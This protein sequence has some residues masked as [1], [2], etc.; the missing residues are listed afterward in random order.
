MPSQRRSCARRWPQQRLSCAATV[1]RPAL[2]ALV[3]LRTMSLLRLNLC[4]CTSMA[5]NGDNL[6]SLLHECSQ[7]PSSQHVATVPGF[8]VAAA[9]YRSSFVRVVSA[10]Q[11]VPNCG[12]PPDCIV[13]SMPL[14]SR[15]S[16]ARCLSIVRTCCFCSVCAASFCLCLVRLGVPDLHLLHSVLAAARCPSSFEEAL[17][18]CHVFLNWG[19]PAQLI[20][21]PCPLGVQ[22]SNEGSG[23]KLGGTKKAASSWLNTSEY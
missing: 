1:L 18:M 9:G 21:F 17:F 10:C 13:L 8:V 22:D 14:L 20:H 23:C 15:N 4:F 5:L 19:V 2:L 7:P 6:F 3:R 12:N 16:L 11:A